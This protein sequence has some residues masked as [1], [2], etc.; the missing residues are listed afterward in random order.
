MIIKLPHDPEITEINVVGRQHMD[1]KCLYI[2][3]LLKL[4]SKE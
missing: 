4:D 1:G 3:W 2:V